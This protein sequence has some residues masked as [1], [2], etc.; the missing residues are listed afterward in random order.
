MKLLL[1][2]VFYILT[3]VVLFGTV[4]YLSVPSPH[5]PK[6]PSDSVQS[7]EKADVEN[8]YQRRAYFTDFSR[9]DILKHYEQEF[10]KQNLLLNISYTVTYP[11]EDAQVLIRDQT[12]SV[13]L[14]E[15][16]HPF[17]ESLFVNVFEAKTAKDEIWYRGVH[18]ERKITVRYVPSDPRLRV[19][20]LTAAVLGLLF[21]LREI[22]TTFFNIAKRIVKK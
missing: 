11:P 2:I 9:E 19:G 21:L 6:P 20:I 7:V 17:R 12:R 4:A 16:I 10:K 22:L 5:F 3:A 18:Y 13:Y 1:N 15:I 8:F 14:P